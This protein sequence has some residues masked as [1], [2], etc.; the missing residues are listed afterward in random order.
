MVDVG[1]SRDGESEL[2][3]RELEEVAIVLRILD[4][5]VLGFT[6]LSSLTDAV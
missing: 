6:G 3:F 1:H 2:F 4:Q 5:L